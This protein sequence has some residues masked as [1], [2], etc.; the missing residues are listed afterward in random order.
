M[1]WTHHVVHW[2]DGGETTA[3]NLVMRGDAKAEVGLL[4]E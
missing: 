2:V 4:V 1:M 3:E